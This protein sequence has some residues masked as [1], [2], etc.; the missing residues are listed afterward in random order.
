MAEFVSCHRNEPSGALHGIMQ[1]QAFTQ[2]DAHIFC[3]EDQINSES[4]AFCNLL[5]DIY[6]DFGFE[7]IR[8]KFSDRPEVR[9]GDDATWDKSEAALRGATDAAGLETVLNPGEGA[10][11][12]PKLEFVLRDAIGRDWQCGTLQVD[13]V[14]PERLDAEYVA[15]DGIRRRPVMLHR[16]ILGSLERWIGILIEQY[17]GRMPV[18][19]SPIQLVVAAITDSANDYAEQVFNAAPV[20]RD[21]R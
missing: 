16:A 18:W 14:L 21:A 9:A 7:D 10:F 17:S 20:S 3:T 12:G 19:L 15:E 5:Q 6:R 8:V 2:D 4:V 13:F 1:V 11:Y